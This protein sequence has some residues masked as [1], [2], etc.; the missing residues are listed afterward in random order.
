MAIRK[1][2]S[3]TR[4]ARPAVR[5]RKKQTEKRGAAAPRRE[6]R[7]GQH[8]TL[9]LR[10]FEPSFTVNDIEQ[11]VHF[12]TNILGFI[13]IE[14]MTD[15]A[16]L[17]G[18]IVKAG[19]CTIGLSQDDWAK[20]RNRKKGEGVRVWCKTAQD[21]DVMATRITAA[22]GQL[23]DKPENQPWGVR[24]LSVKDPDGFLLTI[25]RDS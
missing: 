18:V 22:G 16:V 14:E 8:E 17:Q 21:I 25:Y 4:S 3:G 2:R 13:V 11:S 19:V 7:R 24:S 1:P 6:R 12:Y 23:A 20:G 5:G 15:G 10:S 9:R